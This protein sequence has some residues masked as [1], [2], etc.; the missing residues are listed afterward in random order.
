MDASKGCSPPNRDPASWLITAS[1]LLLA[2]AVRLPGLGQ[3][4]WYDEVCYTRAYFDDPARLSF[5]L[6]EDVHPPLYALLLLAWTHLFGDAEWVVR[7]PSLGCGLVTVVLLWDVAQRGFGNGVATLAAAALALSPAHV[8]YSQENKVNMLAVVLATAAVRS[9]SRALDDGRGRDFALVAA[10]ASL[11]LWTHASALF[12]LAP[13]V[14][15]ALWQT[16]DE[17]GIRRRLLLTT[18]TVALCTAPLVVMK[19]MQDGSL[20]RGYLRPFGP[21]AWYSFALLWLPHGSALRDHNPYK[22]LAHLLD[23][24]MALFVL[25]IA[26]ATLLALG[27]RAAWR[28]TRHASPTAQTSGRSVRQLLLPWLVGPPLLMALG[29]LVVPDIFIERNLL[30][31]TAPYALTLALGAATLS[32]L[33]TRR[34]ASAVILGLA[35]AGLLAMHVRDESWTVYKPRPDWQSLSRFLARQLDEGRTVQLLFDGPNNELYYYRP[36]YL[37]VDRD[38]EVPQRLRALN[39]CKTRGVRWAALRLQPGVDVYLVHNPYWSGCHAQLLDALK[40]NGLALAPT[41]HF[42]SLDLLR[43]TRILR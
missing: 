32:R 35:G 20:A 42:R 10:F 31:V 39:L 9:L 19:V 29:S 33:W 16:W 8:W 18:A 43:I 4:L 30:V 15:V 5:L 24:P 40:G 38:G 27:L 3:S 14:G 7:L 37:M 1:V 25:D 41:A 17:P 28:A 23:E 13:M 34:L 12:V 36:R 2:L 6:W 11:C 26:A 21:A 22:P